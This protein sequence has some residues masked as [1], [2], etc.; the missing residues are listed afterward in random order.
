MFVLCWCQ[1]FFTYLIV[2]SHPSTHRS[3]T[4]ISDWH[5]FWIYKTQR[6][7]IT[8]WSCHRKIYSTSRTTIGWK[9][10]L[11]PCSVRVG[12]PSVVYVWLSLNLSNLNLREFY[13]GSFTTTDGSLFQEPTTQLENKC[14][15]LVILPFESFSL[16]P[17]IILSCEILI[18]WINFQIYIQTY[19]ERDY[20]TS[21]HEITL[22]GLTWH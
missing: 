9:T 3:A 18:I 5:V 2:K 11:L 8:D 16:C 12:V 22:D 21:R 13:E 1:L 20:L 19:N 6:G 17:Q 14:C 4:P 15:L 7:Q 10:E